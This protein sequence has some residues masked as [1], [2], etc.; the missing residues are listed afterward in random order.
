MNW[1]EVGVPL[2]LERETDHTYRR[3]ESRTHRRSRLGRSV[4]VHDGTEEV[5]PRIDFLREF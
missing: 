5:E 3:I 2:P 4:S 1:G